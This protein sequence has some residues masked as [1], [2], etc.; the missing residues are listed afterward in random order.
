ML[1][2]SGIYEVHNIK[3]AAIQVM[4]K[5]NKKTSSKMVHS[6]GRQGT[7]VQYLY[8][9]PEQNNNVNFEVMLSCALSF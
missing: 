4:G 1:Q 6:I 2:K 9:I 7:K 3:D 5:I 8:I